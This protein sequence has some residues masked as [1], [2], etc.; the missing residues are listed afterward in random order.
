VPIEI[1]GLSPLLQVFDM[2]TSIRF[3]RDMLGFAVTGASPALSD[4]P[5]D[6]NWVMLQQCNATV[7]LNTAFEPEHR[8]AA[9]EPVRVNHHDDTCLYFE[10]PDVD[11]AYEHLRAKGLEL[12]KPKVAYYGM[13][14]LYLKDPD[15]FGLCFQWKA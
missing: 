15:G 9:P 2:A 5:V 1:Q 14:Q 11:G 10:C 4:N 12:A 13:K 6:V 3:Y 8:P 7:M